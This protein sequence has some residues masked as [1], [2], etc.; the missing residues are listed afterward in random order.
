MEI[1]QKLTDAKKEA[2]DNGA[3]ITHFQNE[4]DKLKLEDIE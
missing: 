4:H 3:R 2:T 1:T